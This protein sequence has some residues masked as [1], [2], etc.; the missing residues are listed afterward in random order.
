ME[1]V[2]LDASVI[3]KW[4]SKE[5]DSDKAI[6]YLHAFFENKVSIIV[7][8]LL[9]YEL[10]NVLISKKVQKKEV[11]DIKRRLKDLQMEVKDIGLEW[12]RNIYENS[13]D[14]SISFYDAT[15]IT[16]M[17]NKNCKFVTADKKLYEKVKGKFSLTELLQLTVFLSFAMIVSTRGVVYSAHEAQMGPF[18]SNNE[19]ELSY[20]GETL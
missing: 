7:P 19:R 1:K 6:V 2:I 15:Y 18:T 3:I 13:L 17:Q 11:S 8:S 10:G 20:I 4:F 14:Y 9:F 5:D 16:L 12:F